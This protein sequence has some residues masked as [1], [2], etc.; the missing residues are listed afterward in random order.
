[1]KNFFKSFIKSVVPKPSSKRKASMQQRLDG[2]SKEL[3]ESKAMKELRKSVSIWPKEK[4]LDI[5]WKTLTLMDVNGRRR[6]KLTKT[7]SKYF[8]MIEKYCNRMAY[9]DRNYKSLKDYYSKFKNL[10]NTNNRR[11]ARSK[12]KKSR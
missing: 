10:Y 3:L 1:M 5:M 12:T 8:M 9:N 7:E 11:I 2:L 4:F 6:N